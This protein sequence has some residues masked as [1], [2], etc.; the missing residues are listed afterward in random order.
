[1]LK[2][3]LDSWR[4]IAL[5]RQGIGESD[6]FGTGVAGV[7]KAINTLGYI[8]IDTLYVIERAHH[9]NLWNRVKDYQPGNLDELVAQR[10]TFEHWH[11]ALSYLPIDDYR[12]AIPFMQRIK[13]GKTPYYKNRDHKLMDSILERIKVDGPIKLRDLKETTAP[14]QKGMWNSRPA[15]SA[16]EVLFLQGDIMVSGREK[17]ERIYDLPENILPGHISTKCP[18]LNEYAN[19]LIDT[20]LRANGFATLKYILHGKSTA[21]LK[22]QVQDALDL[23]LHSG[24]I[25]CHETDYMPPIYALKNIRENTSSI[26]QGSVKILSPFDN[27]IIHRDR[28]EELFDFSYRLECYTPVAKRQYGYFCLPV[29]FGNTLVGR[30]DCKA[31]RKEGV[32]KLLHVHCE[33]SIHNP[34]EFFAA[35]AKEMRRF[36][37]FNQCDDIKIQKL[38]PG[39]YKTLLKEKLQNTVSN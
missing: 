31:D 17:M 1:M 34:E 6:L 38:S 36:A 12:Y 32:F 9:H 28:A 27:A 18:T 10:K 30:V 24:T 22:K 21:A 14:I 16:L 33:K 8:Q 19:Y 7:E 11:H 2:K 39:K 15:K 37:R 3:N 26:A 13:S 23:K 29:V 25:E 4:N 20:T 5:Q 35:F